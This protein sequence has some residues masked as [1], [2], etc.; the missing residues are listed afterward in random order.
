MVM[1]SAPTS[2]LVMAKAQL[3]LELAIIPFDPPPQLGRGDQIMEPGRLW[4]GRKPVFERLLVT[5]RL[6]DQEPYFGAWMA[7]IIVSG[8][9][10]QTH[11]GE[12]GCK[13]DIATL[14][15]RDSL[16]RVGRQTFRKR[17]G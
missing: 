16:P 15:P 6:V 9:D 12:A 7:Q 5:F 3:L 17:L 11:G 2:T 13:I 8:R 10:T 1:K 4:Q 14:A